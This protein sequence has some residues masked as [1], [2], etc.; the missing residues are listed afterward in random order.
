MKIVFHTSAGIYTSI[1][2]HDIDMTEND[3]NEFI[4]HFSEILNEKILFSFTDEHG[5]II[6]L[7]AEVLRTTVVHIIKD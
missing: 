1:G 3:M 4:Q 5:N 6:I 7:P 2:S